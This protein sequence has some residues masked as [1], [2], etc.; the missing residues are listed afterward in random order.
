MSDIEKWK[1]H[2]P[3]ESLRTE[4]ATW[5]LNKEQWQAARGFSFATFR[6]DGAVS[7][8][9]FHNP[10]GSIVHS[11][12]FYDQTGR[13]TESNSWFNDGPI[14]KVV[15]QYDDAMRHV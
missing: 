1:V 9:D 2:G 13:L 8:S 6:P 4:H 10:D 7:T 11:R 5:D 14:D 3:V 15:Y 12:W